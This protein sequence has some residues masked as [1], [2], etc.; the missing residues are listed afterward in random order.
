MGARHVHSLPGLGYIGG[1]STQ[2]ARERYH[3]VI[4]NNQHHVQQKARIVP[5]PPRTRPVNRSHDKAEESPPQTERARAH[6]P[7]GPLSASSLE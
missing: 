2:K 3:S 6:A 1:V 4:I 5:K 7:W